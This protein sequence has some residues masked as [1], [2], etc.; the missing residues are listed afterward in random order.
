M[1]QLLERF[2]AAIS[3]QLGLAVQGQP[4]AQ[5]SE[6]LQERA[7][8]NGC[9]AAD[10]VARFERAGTPAELDALARRLTVGETYFFRHTQ[11][12]D[13]LRALVRS[14]PWLA[15]GGQP[16]VLCVGC[17][18]GEEPFSIAVV[19]RELQPDR[20]PSITAVDINSASL[21]RARRGRYSQW[22]L[23]ETP[24]SVIDACFR[25][26]GRELVLDPRIVD[27]VQLVHGNLAGHDADPF[28]PGA[29]DVVF[30]RNVVMYF[31]PEKCRQAVERLARVLAP[32]GYLFLSSAETLRG[33][34][35]DFHLCHTHDAFYYQRK[36]AEREPT[37]RAVPG[38]TGPT[39][40]VAAKATASGDWVGDIGRATAR[41]QALSDAPARARTGASPATAPVARSA[42]SASDVGVILQLLH[43]ERFSEALAGVRNLPSELASDPD[44]LLLEAVLLVSSA[45]LELA[46]HRCAR[47]LEVDDLHAGAHYVLGLCAAGDGRLDAAAHHHR[48]ATYLDPGFAM[49]RL[50]LGL[51][52]RRSGQGAAAKR[53]LAQARSLLEREDA[54]RLLLF[55]GGFGRSALLALCDAELSC[56]RESA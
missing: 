3:R 52:L 51:M 1:M 19:L 29:Y 40:T 7:A 23:R 39:D 14:E 49:P 34:S 30:C 26:S 32:G 11:Q 33:L 20:K 4:F 24:P 31:T 9:D 35:N 15:G 8:A 44:V 42:T 53:E 56:G 5:L 38:S 17:A 46:T 25:P 27:C 36:G 41:V 2:G 12:F 22:S 50:H 43:E 37:R 10:Y 48:V 13:A 45:Q 6:V 16:R 28:R 54:A 47:L 18:S 55:G 21:E